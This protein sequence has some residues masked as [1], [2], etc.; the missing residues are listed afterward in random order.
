MGAPPRTQLTCLP[1]HSNN[2]VGIG[3]DIVVPEPKYH[4]AALSQETVARIMFAGPCVL[5]AVCLDGDSERWTGEV[6]HERWHRMLT[7]EVPTDPMA[8]QTRPESALGNRRR[9]A[10]AARHLDFVRHLRKPYGRVDCQSID[11]IA[12]GGR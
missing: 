3:Q 7:P 1:D 11:R 5:S 2:A 10:G 6:Q 8:P 12:T 4:P 9:S